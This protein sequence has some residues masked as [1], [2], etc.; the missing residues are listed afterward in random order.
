MTDLPKR[1]LGRTGLQV[2]TL[3]FGALELRGMV[4]GVGRPLMPGQPER[5]LHA[6][7]DAGINYI[8]VAVDYGEAEE[9]LGRCI[10]GRRHEFFLASKCGCPLDVSRFS[11]S[12]RTR[13]GTPLPRLHDY[14][15]QHI[16][17][18]CHQ[19]LRR[20]KT[21]YLDVLQ[22]HF[23]PAKELL[24]REGAIQTLQDLKQAGKIR[25][26]GVSSILPNLIDHI[27]MGVFD[28]FQIPYSALQPEHEAAIAE[29]AKAGSGIVIRGGVA[30]GEPGAGQSSA[31]VW[32][33]WKQAQLDALLEGMSAT[34]FMLRFT[35]TNPDMHTTIVGTLN[36]AHLQE[37]V[38]AVLKGPL[39]A[40]MYHEAKRRLADARAVLPPS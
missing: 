38:S 5:I 21:D 15:R 40:P 32:K 14:S 36:P 39:P 27:H 28:V 35:I 18:A 22:F 13:Y 12:E 26:L 1:S 33:L 30:R 37:N 8:D 10:A 11:P 31:D 25:F 20:M 29:A 24:E 34:E 16:I 3:G 19:S 9:H 6:V 7:L 2:T 23:S 17:D 4:A